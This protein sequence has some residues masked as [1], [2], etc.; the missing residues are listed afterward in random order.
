MRDKRYLQRTPLLLEISPIAA[1]S[2]ETIFAGPALGDQ[3]AQ[4]VPPA[5]P[6]IL[7]LIMGL[8][9]HAVLV[10]MKDV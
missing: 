5:W 4:H 3:A 8:P 2:P 6:V 7:L 9:A 1:Q 10:A